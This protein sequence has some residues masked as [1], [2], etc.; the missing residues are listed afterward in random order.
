M[1]RRHTLPYAARYYRHT[2]RHFTPA[3]AAADDM[4][5]LMLLPLILLWLY[6]LLIDILL[7]MPRFACFAYVTPAPLPYV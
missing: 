7:P 4:L 2:S 1:L 5:L 3:T 6:M